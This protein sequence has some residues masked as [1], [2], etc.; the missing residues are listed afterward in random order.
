L[1]KTLKIV[2]SVIN[3]YWN[4]TTQI[5]DDPA[6]N[7]LPVHS[8]HLIPISTELS[9]GALVGVLRTCNSV[10]GLLFLKCKRITGAIV[11]LL[12]RNKR[13]LQSCNN[14]KKCKKR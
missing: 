1:K 5:K 11:N 2:T 3:R 4:P 13:A 7:S 8:K 14:Q 10:K 9:R 12:Q 6:T